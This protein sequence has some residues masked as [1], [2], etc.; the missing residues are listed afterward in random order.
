M[1]MSN[2]N[3]KVD[4]PVLG[5]FR[6]LHIPKWKLYGLLILL[7]INSPYALA[8]ELDMKHEK[9]N[10]CD[11]NAQN[12][13]DLE[14]KLN[15]AVLFSN[16]TRLASF[17][18]NT[19]SEPQHSKKINP[20]LNKLTGIPLGKIHSIFFRCSISDRNTNEWL[21]MVLENEE[22]IITKLNLYLFYVGE[23][24]SSRNEPITSDRFASSTE[25]AKAINDK[26][27]SH[28]YSRKAF[29]DEMLNGGFLLHRS[30]N[31][32]QGK[33]DIY[34]LPPLPPESILGLSGVYFGPNASI[35]IGVAF[36]SMN[37]NLLHAKPI[38][39]GLRACFISED[40]GKQFV[41][42]LNKNYP[43]SWF[44]KLLVNSDL[45]K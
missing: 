39:H 45:K 23:N 8:R 26:N 18:Q 11:Y 15:Q 6:K 14:K 29:R 7:F 30:C 13:K 42:Y 21:L 38:Q 37:E 34:F 32:E 43:N 41:E 27:E 40:Y 4:L 35:K 25:L 22:K 10:I 12:I 5:I 36:S 31:N 24:F 44:D 1:N 17:F 3:I 19:P 20:K 28:K 9:I 2:R 16:E 33:T